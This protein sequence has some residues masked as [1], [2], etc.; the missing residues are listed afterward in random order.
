MH[1]PHSLILQ[2]AAQSHPIYTLFRGPEGGM[3]GMEYQ[4][5]MVEMESKESK[6][7]GETLVSR[8]HLACEVCM[9]FGFYIPHF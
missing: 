1:S 8:D 7:R 6:G 9:D 5:E 4:D 3:V 2:V